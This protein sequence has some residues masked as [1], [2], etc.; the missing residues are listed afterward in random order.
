MAQHHEWLGD[1]GSNS[2]ADQLAVGF[3]RLRFTPLLEQEYLDFVRNDR[4]ELQRTALPGAIVLWLGFTAVDQLLIESV[5][6]WWMLA[7]RLSVLAFLLVCGFLLI[8]RRY[9][10]LLNPLTIACISVLG[11]GA[12]AVVGIAHG[13]DPSYPYE[14]LLLVCMAGYFLAGLGLSVALIS[15]ALML[16]SYLL[17]E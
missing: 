16:S 8:Q 14:G 1:V 9:T 12:A 5:E 2:Y 3:R 6:R 15:P 4:F 13:V 10:Q 11:V 17:F 7:V